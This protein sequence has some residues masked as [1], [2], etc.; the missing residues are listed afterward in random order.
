MWPPATTSTSAPDN[1]REVQVLID[2]T[3]RIGD[4]EAYRRD[5]TGWRGFVRWSEG[6]GLH[7]HDWV[8]EKR[9]RKP[10]THAAACDPVPNG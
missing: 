10:E 9:L 5:D 6:P 8:G 4:L 3:W 1:V 7:H 2:G